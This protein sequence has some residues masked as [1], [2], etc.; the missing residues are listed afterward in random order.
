MFLQ[1]KDDLLYSSGVVKS[2]ICPTEVNFIRFALNEVRPTS[3]DTKDML[4]SNVYGKTSIPWR[5]KRMTHK[6]GFNFIIV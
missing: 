5:K 6:Q 3:L 4:I 2:L 1:L